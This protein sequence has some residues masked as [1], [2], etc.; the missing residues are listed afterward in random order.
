MISRRVT[1][2]NKRGLHAR[3]AALFVTLAAGFQSKILLKQGD[4][5]LNGK[6][7]LGIMTLAAAKGSTLEL[8]IDGPDEQ[9]ALEKLSNLVA[10]G[11][12]E[13]D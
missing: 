8:I 5:A 9:A 4:L 11:F 2:V 1:I 13:Q 10:R 12:D 6:S 3:A 7:I